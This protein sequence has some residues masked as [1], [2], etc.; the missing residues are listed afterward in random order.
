MA[1]DQGE[2]DRRAFEGEVIELEAEERR[3]ERVFVG[4]WGCSSRWLL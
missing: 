2:E 1:V 3:G 4:D